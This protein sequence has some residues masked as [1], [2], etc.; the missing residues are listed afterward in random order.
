MELISVVVPIY[1]SELYL[2]RCIISIVEQTYRNL[3]IILVD[4]GSPDS[5]PQIC[6]KWEKKDSRI[7]VIHQKNSGV[8]MARN[9][10][11]SNA[12]GKYL[13]MVDSDDY[14]YYG[15]VEALYK[16]MKSHD[17]DLSICDFIEGSASTFEFIYD[18]SAS[19]EVIKAENALKRIYIDSKK[20]LQYV[21]PWGKLYKKELFEGI[22]YPE[23]KIFEDIYVTHQI[24][25]RCDKIAVLPQK[26]VYY[27]Q[28]P[29]SIMNKK[30]HVGKLDYL[31]ALKQRIEFYR[32]HD[33]NELTQIAYDEYIHAL[34]WEYS[35]A[36]DLLAD[37]KVMEGIIGSYRSIYQKGYSSKRYPK[38]NELFLRVF[39]FNPELIMLYWKITAKLKKEF[40]K[41]RSFH[42]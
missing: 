35:R 5:C 39:N 3:E 8:S 9:A 40:S 18:L 24:L 1:K 2:D 10:G 25:Y 28:Y 37:K 27:F 13:M 38:E 20:A 22:Q 11:I 23:G 14:I 29:E 30:F 12:N 32:N 34:I 26:L 31:G 19:V 21:V 36:K 33:L 16:E 6:D 17:A 7:K 41:T 15:M 42:E 4:D